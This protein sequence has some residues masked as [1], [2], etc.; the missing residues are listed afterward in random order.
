MYF[1]GLL[2]ER[3][4]V[5]RVKGRDT[6][7]WEPRSVGIRNEPLDAR[8]YAT[9][10]LELLNPNFEM[11][12]QR[13]TKRTNTVPMPKLKQPVYHEKLEEK[14]PE[15]IPEVKKPAMKRSVPSGFFK[16]GLRM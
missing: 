6:I 1:K 7:T 10:A 9:G 4:V 15:P 16:R 3:M 8:V 5:K 11:H 13:R 2:S 14:K 12:R